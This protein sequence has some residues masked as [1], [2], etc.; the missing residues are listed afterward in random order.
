METGKV[1]VNLYP[2]HLM[3]TVHKILI[4]GAI[5]VEKALLSI[6]QLSEKKT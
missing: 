5:V 6:G 4:H 3:S 1:Y 2:W